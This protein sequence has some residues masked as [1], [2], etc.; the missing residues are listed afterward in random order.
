M[1]VSAIM[2]AVILLDQLTKWWAVHRLQAVDEIPLIPG[3]LY[4]KYTTNEGMAFGMLKDHRWIF[5]VLTSLIL[6]VIA[7][8]LIKT[9]HRQK[10]PLLNVSLGLILGGGI[11]N[12]IDRVFFADTLFCGKVVD[13]IDFRLIH[14]AI[15]NVADAAVCIGEALLIIYILWVDGKKAGTGTY[16]SFSEKPYENPK[17]HSDHDA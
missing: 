4:L 1:L 3:V 12:M 6:V 15:F 10:H 11:G 8:F 16:F 7:V 9:R 17:E 14:F 13:F 5:L 2:Y